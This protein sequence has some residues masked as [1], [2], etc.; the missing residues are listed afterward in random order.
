[1]RREIPGPVLAVVAEVL[2]TAETHASLDT[3]FHYAGA[4]G[5]PPAGSKQ[6]KALEWLRRTNRDRSVDPFK[7]LGRLLEN[8]IELF[9]DH[10][11]SVNPYSEERWQKLM[12]A[13]AQ[14]ELQYATGGM[15]IGALASPSRT[16]EQLIR[17][18]DLTSINEEFDRALRNIESSPREA[19]SAACN[20]L[21]S[22][23]KT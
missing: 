6:V 1:M 10:C 18:G 14:Y 17:D 13:L 11:G 20:I 15:V 23:C 3:L 5:E 2:A 12:R 16:L 7:V 4:P 8:H 21:E 9:A 19:V 22:V